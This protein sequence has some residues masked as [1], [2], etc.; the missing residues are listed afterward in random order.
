MSLQA[1]RYRRISD[2]SEQIANQDQDTCSMIERLGAVLDT[3]RDYA[4][5]GSAWADR[6]KLPD[7]ERLLRDL[8]AGDLRGCLVVTWA[9]D[10]LARNTFDLVS[11]TKAIKDGGARLVSVKEPWADTG[12]MGE[13]L[14]FLAGWV[15]QQE[16]ARK[17]ERVK[18]AFA[19][20]RAAGER[21]GR[22][23]KTIDWALL[24]RMKGEGFGLRRIA[25]A[26]D[27]SV[28]TVHKALKSRKTLSETHGL[29]GPA[30]G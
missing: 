12:G 1:A 3:T 7:R 27:V 16:S 20:K 10:R 8:A 22:K 11:I 21:L 18:A 9:L 4:D 17:S 6:P 26:L 28:G 29:P 25:K 23:P 24:E 2:K 19:R 5:I 15:A 13:V 14:I 30:G